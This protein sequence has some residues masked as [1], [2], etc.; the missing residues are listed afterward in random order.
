M[1]I[2]NYLDDAFHK[3]TEKAKNTIEETLNEL[4][5]S[6]NNKLNESDL[7]KN[8]R[9][10][11]SLLNKFQ[12]ENAI[13]A[14]YRDIMALSRSHIIE[15]YYQRTIEKGEMYY[16]YNTSSS[17]ENTYLMTIPLKEKSHEIIEIKKNELPDNAGVDSVLRFKNGKYELDTQATNYIFNE[18]NKKF[19]DLLNEQ[20]KW[21]Q[22]FRVEG[23]TYKTVEVQDNSI[24]LI[25][26]DNPNYLNN[27]P[28]EEVTI[29]KETINSTQNG[30][31]FRY[32]D[33]EYLHIK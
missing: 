23:H 19:N 15:D 12:N 24:W 17:K 11:I 27:Y 20:E 5:E 10:D 1:N 25:D 29:S 2:N 16:I 31:Y 8:E 3:T 18:M 33:G 21:L 28:F 26:I 9:S 7:L 13:T 30:D 6:I 32:V 14:K 22:S 4:K